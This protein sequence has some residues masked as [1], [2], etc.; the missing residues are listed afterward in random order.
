M[1]F[2]N[3]VVSLPG[4]GF[5]YQSLAKSEEKGNSETLL[6]RYD[7]TEDYFQHNNSSTIQTHAVLGGANISAIKPKEWRGAESIHN[8]D[9][10]NTTP[11]IGSGELAFSAGVTIENLTS[12]DVFQD[13]P[14]AFAA[15][16]S[17]NYLFNKGGISSSPTAAI[18]PVVGNSVKIDAVGHHIRVLDSGSACDLDENWVRSIRYTPKTITPGAEVF[19][20]SKGYQD[21][22]LCQVAISYDDTNIYR[23]IGGSKVVVAS[24]SI[25][26][27]DEQFVFTLYYMGQNIDSQGGAIIKR[28][29]FGIND[30]IVR[31]PSTDNIGVVTSALT[32]MIGGIR[33]LNVEDTPS[34]A[35][36]Q[37]NYRQLLRYGRERITS[38]YVLDDLQIRNYVNYTTSIFVHGSGDSK[39]NGSGGSS[40]DRSLCWFFLL[41]SRM[42]A[43]GLDVLFANQGVSGSQFGSHAPNTLPL[44]AWQSG[45]LSYN[46]NYANVTRACKEFGCDML[47]AYSG[48]NEYINQAEPALPYNW[49]KQ[50]EACKMASAECASYGVPYISNTA[51]LESSDT[52][53]YDKEVYEDVRRHMLMASSRVTD[54]YRDL[55]DPVA[56]QAHYDFF[57]DNVHLSLPGNVLEADVH[58]PYV[59]GLLDSPKLFYPELTI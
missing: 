50:M 39:M 28:D 46:I 38:K 47:I 24:T 33:T 20:W 8:L 44:P 5:A 56:L 34:E 49:A 59:L 41:E 23:T 15:D 43:R 25:L 10:L 35:N 16:N 7:A 12:V 31:Q 48:T 6:Q 53:G 3:Y 1:A 4:G 36:A 45:T 57:E 30:T 22:T 37:G 55:I 27:I 14:K 26:A 32:E 13:D 58:E 42:K 40:D 21:S 2:D 11:K 29:A 17:Y 52:P 54:S 51:G 9:T 18:V 19:I